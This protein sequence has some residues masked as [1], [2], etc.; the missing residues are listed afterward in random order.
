MNK[1]W[2]LKVLDLDSLD[3]N[4]DFLFAVSAAN[5]LD[6][7]DAASKYN[8]DKK[9]LDNTQTSCAVAPTDKTEVLVVANTGRR[10]S[11]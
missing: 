3:W 8:R 7:R 10:P 4:T 9:W 1:V 5:E 2:I 11:D 6:A